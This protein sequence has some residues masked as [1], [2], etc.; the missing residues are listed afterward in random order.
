MI[1]V[2]EALEKILSN[3]TVLEEEESPILDSLGQVLSEDISSSISVPPWDNAAMDG[4]AIRSEDTL[5]ASEQAPRSLRV[6]DTV[7]AGAISDVRVEPGTAIRIMT[8]A[9]VPKG[10]D[11]VVRFEDTNEMLQQAPLAEIG[12]LK[13]VAPGLNI[14]CAG[15]DIAEGS[16]VIGKGVV[17]RPSEVGILASLGRSMVKVIRRPVVAILATGDELVDVGEVLPPGKIYNSN[18]YSLASLVKYYGGIPWIL[19]I[20]RDNEGSLVRSLRQGLTADMLLTSG[21]VSVG[22][23]DVVKDVLAKQGEIGFWTVCMK[24][25]KPLAFGMIKGVDGVGVVRS[26]PHL[27]LPGNPVSSMITFEL[28]ARTAILKMMGRHDLT[29]SL[30]KAVLEDSIANKDRRRIF[31]RVALERRGEHYFAKLT[32]PQGSGILTSMS[33]ANALAII[34]EDQEQV[35]AGETVSVMMLDWLGDRGGI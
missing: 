30:I 1:S 5:G 14:R 8:G 31:T 21:G 10:A 6:I 22:D 20:A 12:V 2:E 17:I 16:Q 32:G 7:A 19:G 18:S 27:G 23:Y 33:L 4:Y 15:E 3:V 34:P 9:P 35:V 28:F 11:S 13:E 26:I 25:G 29:H 24:P